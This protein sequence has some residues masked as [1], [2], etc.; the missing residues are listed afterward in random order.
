MWQSFAMGS[1]QGAAPIAPVCFAAMGTRWNE[2]FYHAS[3][4]TRQSITG[5]NYTIAI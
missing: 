2:S 1:C 5:W 4:I 3:R